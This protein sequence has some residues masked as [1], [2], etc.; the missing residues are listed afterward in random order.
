MSVTFMT[1]GL[2]IAQYPERAVT[3][4]VPYAAGGAT[5]ASARLMAEALRKQGQGNFIVENVPGAGTTIGT[6]RVARAASDGYTLLWGGLSANA[7]APNLYANLPYDGAQSFAP[8]TMVASQPYVLFVNGSS[9]IK[10]VNDL[11]DAAKARPEALNFATPGQGSS[12][13]LMTEMFLNA[14]GIKAQHVPYK[15]AAPAMAGVL[16]GEVQMMFDT[17]TAPMPMFK[18]GR[19]KPL[20]VTSEKRIAELPDVP[21][22]KE[23]GL[24]GLEAS[25]WFALFAPRGTPKSIVMKL[26]NMTTKALA[27]PSVREQLE[28]GLFT[29]QSSTPDELTQRVEKERAKWGRIIKEKSIGLE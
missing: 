13:H 16:S 1:S 6:A 20:A 5:D 27:D 23:A 14:A 11:L 29:V 19:L 25:T 4:V 7:I 22:F 12:P 18:S 24:T 3:I 28:K 21:T 2:A 9:P 26:N 15:G 10:S 8:I 17:P